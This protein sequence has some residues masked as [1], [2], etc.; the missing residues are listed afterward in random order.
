[1]RLVI[2]TEKN[3]LGF[4]MWNTIPDSIFSREDSVKMMALS[5]FLFLVQALPISILPQ[6]I[7][8]WNEMITD[9]IRN[10]KRKTVGF[11]TL[12]KS[13]DHGGIVLPDLQNYFRATQIIMKWTNDGAKAKWFMIEKKSWFHVQ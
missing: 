3:K 6:R 1:M 5:R 13:K 8:R 9:F 7:K 12:R 10:N 4:T 11:R 2:R